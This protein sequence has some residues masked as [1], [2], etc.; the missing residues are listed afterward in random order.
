MANKNKADLVVKA[1]T[2][3]EKDKKIAEIYSNPAIM[4][5]NAMINLNKG[6]E[7]NLSNMIEALNDFSDKAKNNDLKNVEAM[8]LGQTQLLHKIF[9]KAAISWGHAETMLQYQNHGN[10]ALKAQNLCRMTAA[11]LAD[12]KNP[13]RTTFIKNSAVNQQVNFNPENSA[14]T[15][16]E[17]LSEAKDEAMDTRGTKSTIR[18]D[19]EM[20]TVG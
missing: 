14:K 1:S 7:L 20:A 9:T 15:S 18:N 13:N 12:M 16:N 4:T 11:T 10:I 5:S 3:E 17:L 8:L 6:V 2:E 19:K